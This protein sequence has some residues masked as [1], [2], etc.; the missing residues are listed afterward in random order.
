MTHDVKTLVVPAR[1]I[2]EAVT[3]LSSIRKNCVSSDSMQIDKYKTLVLPEHNFIFF[4]R[5][6]KFVI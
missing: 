1:D 4:A 3:A 2:R 6:E 5:R